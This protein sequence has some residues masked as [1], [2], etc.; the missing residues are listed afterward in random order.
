MIDQGTKI[1]AGL[2]AAQLEQPG[3]GWNQPFL[4][5]LKQRSIKPHRAE[6]VCGLH[7]AADS[8]DLSNQRWLVSW[9]SM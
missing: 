1:I 6:M 2:G 7:A 8:G 3:L 9:A 5:S 4:N